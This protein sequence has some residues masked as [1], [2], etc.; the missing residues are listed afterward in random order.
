M[1]DKKEK[2][3]FEYLLIHFRFVYYPKQQARLV[4]WLARQFLP[5]Y[6]VKQKGFLLTKST[7]KKL[8]IV[9][10]FAP[11]KTF[12]GKR[13]YRINTWLKLP[14]RMVLIQMIMLLLTIALIFISSYFW[15]KEWPLLLSMAVILCAVS[16]LISIGLPQSKCFS[17]MATLTSAIFIARNSNMDL[18]FLKGEMSELPKRLIANRYSAIIWLRDIYNGN[19]LYFYDQKVSSCT[20]KMFFAGDK[21]TTDEILVNNINRYGNEKVPKK[22]LLNLEQ[23]ENYSKQLPRLSNN[24]K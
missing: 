5:E 13:N 21:T 6:Q 12:F 1:N 23:L 4:N 19:K 22:F 15:F 16:S 18:F 3:L 7:N 17:H 10:S 20:E 2:I 11:T 14:K 24:K 8:L 9:N